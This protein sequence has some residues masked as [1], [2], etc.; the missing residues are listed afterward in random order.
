MNYT[1]LIESCQAHTLRT[2][3]TFARSDTGGAPIWARG[4]WLFN[5]WELGS[6]GIY[7]FF[8]GFWEQAHS[9]GDLGSPAKKVKKKSH[10]KA[11][12]EYSYSYLYSY[13]LKYFFSVLSCT[14]YLAKFMITCTRTYLSTVTK[15][16]VL[17][18][19]LPVLLS[20]FF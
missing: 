1:H 7:S 6:T 18:S 13:L 4:A 16:P 19:T 15:N 2:S 5:L 11:G 3:N 14:L 8:Q 20:T 9:F 12:M 17:M 10:L